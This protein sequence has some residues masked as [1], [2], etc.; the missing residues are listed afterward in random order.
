MLPGQITMG[1]PVLA[2]CS[3]TILR[4]EREKFNKIGV[5]ARLKGWIVM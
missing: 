3:A 4:V 5:A 1:N 2:K